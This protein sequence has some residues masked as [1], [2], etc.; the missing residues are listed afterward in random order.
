MQVETITVGPV[1]T[2][3]YLAYDKETQEGFLV[4]PGDQ[5]PLILQTVERCGVRVTHILLTHSHFDHVMALA[6]VAAATGAKIAVYEKEADAVEHPNADVLRALGLPAMDIPQ[7][8]VEIRFHDGDT[9]SCAGERLQIL[10]TPGHTA[11]SICIDTGTVLFSGDT[12]FEDGCGRCDLPGGNFAVLLRSLKRLAQLPGDR[13]VYPGH[14][15][16]TT[17]AR[18]RQVNSAMLCALREDR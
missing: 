3:C 7:A 11:G 16:S 17:L 15:P 10:H 9:L 18:E 8:Q 5:A 2:N 14:G 12:L 13:I 1:Q 4:D 6:E